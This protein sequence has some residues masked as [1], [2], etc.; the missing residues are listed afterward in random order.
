M[1]VA[2]ESR[3][4][5]NPIL[6]IAGR[7]GDGFH[8][9]ATVM[10]ALDLAGSVAVE[11]SDESPA[12]V[13]VSLNGPLA[14]ADIP[15]D[16]SNLAAQAAL[17]VR[18][19]IGSRRSLR[20]AIEKRVPSRAGLGGGSA[21]AAAAACA[22]LAALVDA[23]ARSAHDESLAEL[24]ARLGSDCAFFHHARA[25]AAAVAHGRG[26]DLTSVA[27]TPAWWVSVVTPDVFVSTPAVY[28]ALGLAPG[29]RVM[30]DRDPWL[31]PFGARELAESLFN[32]P[33]DAARERL[34]NDLE[35]AARRAY[36]ALDEWFD[37]ARTS[38]APPMTLAG[39]GASL[40]GIHGCRED[41]EQAVAAVVA[42]AAER[43]RVARFSAVTRVAGLQVAGS[44]EAGSQRAGPQ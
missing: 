27:R 41:A 25:G 4:K 17:G 7:R 35:P 8:D 24:L 32:L 2:F 26:V 34:A 16:A 37:V 33:V 29:A 5:I 18:D 12:G 1:R 14:T 31:D 30:E 11:A 21:D 22:T 23:S 10:V 15:A 19:L 40:F 38:G 42:A 9:L 28:A 44:Q 43:G 13:T 3:A 36:P 39:S 6:R 20:V